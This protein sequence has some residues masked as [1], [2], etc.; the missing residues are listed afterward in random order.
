VSCAKE[1]LLKSTLYGLRI[2]FTRK[3]LIKKIEERLQTPIV[4]LKEYLIYFD[5]FKI[6]L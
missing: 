1:M 6:Y 5:E 4:T 2:N 3:N